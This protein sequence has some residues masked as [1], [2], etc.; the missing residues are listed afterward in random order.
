MSKF[1]F[2]ISV[3]AA[4]LEAETKTGWFTEHGQHLLFQRRTAGILTAV[5]SIVLRYTCQIVTISL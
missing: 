2:F 1:F 3:Y 5:Y 4:C